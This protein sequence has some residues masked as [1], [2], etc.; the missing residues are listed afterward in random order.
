LRH[1]ALK[2]ISGR[3]N[4]L[5]K[6]STAHTNVDLPSETSQVIAELKSL[7]EE[8]REIS[9]N[10]NIHSVCDKL[11]ERFDRFEWSL[12]HILHENTLSGELELLSDI[13]LMLSRAVSLDEVLS[14]MI[15]GLNKVVP[16]DAAGIFIHDDE[17]G[18]IR[19]ITLRG[20]SE[21][22]LDKFR[23]KLHEGISGKVMSSA[24]ELNIPDVLNE[25]SYVSCR[26]STRSELAVPIII[27]DD[28]L[29]CIN[30]ESDKVGAFKEE[31]ILILKDIAAH[32]AIALERARTYDKLVAAHELE[33]E[34]Q[35]SRRIQ[36][37]LLP[38]NPPE[39]PGYDFG[40][41]NVPHQDVGGDYYDYIPINSNNIGLVIADV[42]G[43]GVP[44]GLI[45]SGLRAALRTRIETTYS[46]T[47]IISS[48]NRFLYESTGPEAFVTAFYGVLNT[49]TNELTYV[50]AGH[51]QPIL[52]K[53][54]GNVEILKT[55]GPLLGVIE[56]PV[57]D[58]MTIKLESG[59][60]L[61]LYTDGI[62]EAGGEYENEFGI[63]RVIDIIRERS[64]EEA[65]SIAG[66][67][68]NAVSQW[69]SSYGTGDDRTVMVVKRL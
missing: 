16:Y 13:G 3:E 45:M 1:S 43:K 44:A 2:G 27:G 59:S 30:L 52:M 24:V 34:L 6:S 12:A 69:D 58:Q 33:K 67:I 53:P 15:D 48:I 62:V 26:L 47:W 55:G 21:E 54:D 17:P 35:I 32:A 60:T 40:G 9:E 57:Y 56:N 23:Q 49:E 10:G 65:A 29:G 64:G 68:D 19:A 41:I 8:L 5:T 4:K 14:A 42:A 61:V 50:N 22:Q 25:S 66:S 11:L 51:N 28:V 18:K 36:S 37:A 7:R 31:N 39:I 63:D 46:V 38:K 20:Y